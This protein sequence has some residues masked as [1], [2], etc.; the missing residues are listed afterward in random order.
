MP[1]GTAIGLFSLGL[2]MAL[3]ETTLYERGRELPIVWLPAL[4]GILTA[5]V[6]IS[7]W[8]LLDI[9]ENFLTGANQPRV[10]SAADTAVLVFGLLV[11]GALSYAVF[12]NQH[13]KKSARIA[14][15]HADQFRHAERIANLFYWTTG[16]SVSDWESASNNAEIFYGVPLDQLL[17]VSSNYMKIIHPED[18]ER[19]DSFYRFLRENHRPYE[20]EYRFVRPDGEI[21]TCREVGEPI[22]DKDGGFLKFRGTTQDTTEQRLAEEELRFAKLDA[23]AANRAKSEFLAHMSHE[24]RTP[25]NSII[26]FS[27]LMSRE[28]FGGLGNKRYVEYSETIERSAQH[29][30]ALISDI[31]DLSKVEAGKTDLQETE[32]GIKTLSD[33]AIGLVFGAGDP[34]FVR[35]E[36]RIPDEE[37][38]FFGDRRLILQCITNILSNAKKFTPDDGTIGLI[39]G[40]DPDGGIWLRVTDTGPG[41]ANDDIDRILEPFG[42]ARARVDHAHEGTGLGLPIVKRLC[43]LHG[44][45]ILIDSLIGEGTFVT[46]KFPPERTVHSPKPAKIAN[47]R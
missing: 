11:S 25:L 4:L 24:L 9:E 45:V 37:P 39:M 15:E 30:L 19:V 7:L 32:F 47:A 33:E 43:E 14:K 28:I 42:Q 38:Q 27:Q 20:L 13:S 8:H 3:F 16:P 10:I 31:L 1:F 23:E 17:G 46:L 35:I 40:Q 41:I 5:S 22:F 21:R 26:G 36:N 12:V 6:S 2:G 29:L 18:R 34:H 44:G